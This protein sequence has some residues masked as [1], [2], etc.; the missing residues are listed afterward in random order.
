MV[1]IGDRHFPRPL[2]SKF[3]FISWITKKG[4]QLSARHASDFVHSGSIFIQSFQWPFAPPKTAAD[5]QPAAQ[6]ARMAQRLCRRPAG[7]A[8]GPAGPRAA[9]EP[10]RAPPPPESEAAA[11][12]FLR[13][14]AYTQ[15]AVE[16]PLAPAEERRLA[17]HLFR[18][19]Q[20][21]AD[22]PAALE[23]ELELEPGIEPS[24]EVAPVN[25]NGSGARDRQAGRPL[26]RAAELR[27]SG[28]VTLS[29]LP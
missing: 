29:S 2:G 20:R 23:L 18:F 25:W 11:L 6:Y 21:R 27:P 14:M 12:R 17:H 26:W 16:L 19:L 22:P 10:E 4:G 24:V 15:R 5:R 28:P 1:D 3:Y 9:A 7:A 8:G 13:R